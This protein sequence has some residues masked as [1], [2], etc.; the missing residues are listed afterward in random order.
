SYMETA[1]LAGASTLQQLTGVVLPSI[2][3]YILT[4]LLLICLCACNDFAPSLLIGSGPGRNTQV[5]SVFMYTQA[6]T[7]SNKLGYGAAIAAII[8]V[9]HLVLVTS[10]LRCG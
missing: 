2:K 7:G 9:I 10:H 3:G 8:L 5:L 6:F 1:R 4:N